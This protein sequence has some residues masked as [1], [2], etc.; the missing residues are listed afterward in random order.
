MTARPGGPERVYRGILGL[1]P[2][3]FRHRFGE[4][5]VQ[6]F[7]DRLRD[8]RSGRA[9]GGAVVAWMALLVDVVVT[10]SLEHLRRNRTVAHSLTSAPSLTSRALGSA[11]I[12]AGF[13]ILAAFV[14][15]LPAGLF[16]VR[17][18][19][20][21]LGVLAI[22]IGVHR[23]Q[24][25]RAPLASLAVTVAFVAATAFFVVTVF[26]VEPGHLAAFWSGVTL[27]LASAAFGG[28]SAWI[29]AVSRIGGWAVAI[30][31]LL[32]LTGIDRLGLVS[33]ASP[34]IFNTLSQVGIVSMALGWIILGL[35]VALR[36]STAQVPADR[37]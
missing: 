12:V 18:V 13:V 4:D 10:A 21:A 23:R 20:F 7:H 17:L 16:P 6:L 36:R 26:L 14:I 15:E 32:T 30:G 37:R 34:T 25:S 8:A 3:E 24:A 31:S 28:T 5:M 22:G 35:D 29:G 2:A 33:E 9:P 19:I 11:G 27:W 1:Y